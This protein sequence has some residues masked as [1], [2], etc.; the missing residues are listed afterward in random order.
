MEELFGWSLMKQN[1]GRTYRY[2]CHRSEYYGRYP[3]HRMAPEP[4]PPSDNRL[5]PWPIHQSMRSYPTPSRPTMLPR[6][7]PTSRLAARQVRRHAA[8]IP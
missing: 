4:V 8:M 1:D 2:L 7:T 6:S 5:V 3:R